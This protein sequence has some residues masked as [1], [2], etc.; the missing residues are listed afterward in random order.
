MAFMWKRLYNHYS[1]L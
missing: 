1:A